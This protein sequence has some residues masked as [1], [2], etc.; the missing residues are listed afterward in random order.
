MQIP[1]EDGG[2]SSSSEIVMNYDEVEDIIRRLQ[3]IYNIYSGVIATN[4]KSLEKCQFYLEGE[5]MRVIDVYPKILNKILELADHYNR[6]ASIVEVVRQE[7]KIQDEEL[8]NKL[9]PQE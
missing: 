7:M 5:A 9:Q 1:M 6:A 2:A 4:A 8:H 3:S